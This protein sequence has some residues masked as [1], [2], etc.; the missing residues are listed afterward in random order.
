M[1]D[2][3]IPIIRMLI[4][5]V[6]R[7]GQ[8]RTRERDYLAWIMEKYDIPVRTRAELLAE[9]QSPPRVEHVFSQIKNSHDRA[10]I[11]D[12]LRVVMGIDGAMAPAERAL[13][14]EVS[15][16]QARAAV[17]SGQPIHAR[18]WRDF[19]GIADGPVRR[20]WRRLFG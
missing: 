6:A 16:L 1:S 14:D 4:I 2:N 8:V 13:F 11:L 12:L 3:I 7:D 15:A 18:A 17:I 9:L 10:R 20:W 5:M 19:E